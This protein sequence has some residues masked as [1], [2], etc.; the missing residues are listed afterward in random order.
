[1]GR[2][3]ESGLTRLLLGGAAMLLCPTPARALQPPDCVYDVTIEGA[4]AS[5]LDVEVACQAS[6]GVHDFTLL[7]DSAMAWLS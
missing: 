1:M 4:S 3:A 2:Q 5:A 7:D 6:T